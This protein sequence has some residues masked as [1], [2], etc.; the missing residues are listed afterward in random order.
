M[1]T[2]PV[3][4]VPVAFTPVGPSNFLTFVLSSIKAFT[5]AFTSLLCLFLMNLC[6]TLCSF[7]GLSLV[8][9]ALTSWFE[10]GSSFAT[11]PNPMSEV[12]AFFTQFNQAKTNDLDPVDF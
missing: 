7:S 4:V 1:P 10:V 2:T 5:I 9:V 6:C 11:I 3:F 12:V 8:E